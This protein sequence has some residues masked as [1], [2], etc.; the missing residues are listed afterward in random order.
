MAIESSELFKI[1][2]IDFTRFITVPNY[3]VNQLPVYKEWTDANHVSHHRKIRDRVEGSLTLKFFTV[4]DYELFIR[5]VEENTTEDGYITAT[6]YL[7]N[8]LRAYSGNFY[9][10]FEPQNTLPFMGYKNYDGFELE[11]S[12]R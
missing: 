6:F 9:F 7:N 5:T 10:D 3:E 1:G 8:K 4:E 11:I 12:E 2:T